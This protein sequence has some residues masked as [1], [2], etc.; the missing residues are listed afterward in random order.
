VPPPW[1]PRIDKRDHPVGEAGV[2][3]SL[4]EV[5]KRAA[6][7]GNHPRVKEWAGEQIHG[8]R[9][10]GVSVKGDRARASILLSAVQQT[11]TWVPD[12]VGTEY[13]KGAH[14]LACSRDDKH[15]PCF[16][17]GDCFPEGT[18]VLK[19]GHE[20]TSVESLK[21]GD[22]IWG[23]S[24]WSTVEAVAYK[25][26]LSVDVVKLNNGSDLKLTS[27][28]HVYVRDCIEH[29]MLDEQ[30]DAEALPPDRGWRKPK[31]A[32]CTCDERKEKRTRVSE[33]RRGMMLVQPER[34]PFGKRQHPDVPADHRRAYVEGLFVSDG[35]ADYDYNSRF[36]ISGQDGCP[37]EAQ[38]KEVQ[39]ICAELGVN[40]TW[41]RKSIAV[42]GKEWTLRMQ[43]MGRYA[44]Q[45][46]LLTL[47]LDEACAAASLRGVMADAGKNT[48]GEGFTFTTTSKLLAIQVRVLHRM[49]GI[50]CGW[51]FIEMHGG[52]G[53]N[54]IWRLGVRPRQSKSGRKPWSLKVRDVERSVFSSP[55]WDIQ[56]SDHRVY[57]PE[58]DV[59]V[60]QCDDLCVLLAASFLSVG[61]NTLIVG[62]AY[63]QA[64]MIQHVLCAAR[65]KGEWL[66]ADP[67]YDFALGKCEPYTRE[68]LLSVPNVKVVCDETKCLTNPTNFN[69]DELNF[70]ERGTFVGVDGAPWRVDV[71]FPQRVREIWWL[72]RRR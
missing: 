27:E 70:V 20:L 46:H 63:G 57:L 15:G 23:L 17:S 53:T 58:Y 61:L 24:D 1:Q 36:F 55:C 5:A 28:H 44:P 32:G 59:T 19:E 69:P 12:P 56:T 11:K 52:L 35:W 29:P 41:K 25:G 64:R 60:S 54:P 39:E 18:L 65:V 37:K 62:H 16:N 4:E 3:S 21:P 50:T 43:R 22:K 71:D 48:R 66:Y 10:R 45:K 68:R 8:A 2:R 13:I 6:Q 14:L 38:K 49:F 51:K 42:Y 31:T 34:L 72:G 26:L 9:L 7:G 67:S 40:T 47:D 30:E 33:L